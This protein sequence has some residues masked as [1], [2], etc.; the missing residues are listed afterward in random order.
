[1]AD[2]VPR[3]HILAL[4]A[5]YAIARFRVVK[6]LIHVGDYLSAPL[7]KLLEAPVEMYGRA[8]IFGTKCPKN[9]EKAGFCPSFSSLK[10][11]RR[12]FI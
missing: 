12:E 7:K 1:M 9:K 8:H 5:V 11:S 4:I 6:Q 3:I 10:N 2:A